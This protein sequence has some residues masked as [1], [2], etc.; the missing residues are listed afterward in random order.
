MVKN[1]C[2]A[3]GVT[4]KTNHSLRA[5]G[6]SRMFATNVSHKLIQERSGHLRGG[7]R[8]FLLKGL[9]KV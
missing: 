7:S 5:T 9:F 6:V 2:Q 3:I 4:G 8:N 1:M